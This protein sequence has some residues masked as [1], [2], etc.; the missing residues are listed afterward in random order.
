MFTVFHGKDQANKKS[1][2]LTEE[3]NNNFLKT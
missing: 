2:E 3:K 1:S